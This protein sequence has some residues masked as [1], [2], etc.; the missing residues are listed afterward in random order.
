MRQ[1][2]P[3][4]L[5][6]AAAL[7]KLGEDIRDARRRRR[8]TMALLAERAGINVITLGKIEKGHEST[9]IGAYASV[10][11]GLGMIE[12]FRDIA[13]GSHD[14]TGQML[15]DEKLPMR[16]RIRKNG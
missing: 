2:Y 16:V 9:S 13:D 14:L 10:L 1:K 8:I 5:P 4:P 6:A 12:R 7:R 15:A 3:I 11:Y